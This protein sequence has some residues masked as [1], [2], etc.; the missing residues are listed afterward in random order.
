M[1]AAALLLAVHLRFADGPPLRGLT[2]DTYMTGPF[3]GRGEYVKTRPDVREYTIDTGEATTFRAIVYCPGYEFAL[4]GTMDDATIA[5][6]PLP[7]LPLRGHVISLAHPEAY[8]IEAV[9]YTPWSH[10][11]FGM[12]D[13][14]VASFVVASAP[15]AADGSFALALPDLQRDPAAK[16]RGAFTL[17]I[18]NTKT[19]NIA[20]RKELPIAAEYPRGV[21]IAP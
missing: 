17:L 12:L 5:L 16:G 7:S 9:Y 15:L 11:F 14:M 19:W 1:L 21:M 20:G 6:R 18:R 8:T 10:D 2:I 13:G 3:G 4:L